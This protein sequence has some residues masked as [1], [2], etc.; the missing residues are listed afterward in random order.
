MNSV[1]SGNIDGSGTLVLKV[2]YTRD[3]YTITPAVDNDKAGTVSDVGSYGYENEVCIV[4]STNPG[5]T[6]LGWYE[7][8]TRVC[9]TLTFIFNAEKTVTYTAKWSAD[10]ATYTVNYYKETFTPTGY[11][12][13]L[14]D[15]VIVTSQTG[16]YVSATANSVDGYVLNPQTSVVSGEV[17][18]DNSLVLEV[19]YRNAYY[20]DGDYIYLGEYPQT[21]KSDDVTITKTIDERGYYLGSDGFYYAKYSTYYFKVEPIRWR[22]LTEQDGKAFLFCDIII[23][24]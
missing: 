9:D 23:E 22:I 19:K 24:W 14:F 13:E 21:L 2:Y 17:V 3:V 15:S 6:F 12:T 16:E 8:T 7:G 10:E 18:W 4:A 5:Y 20:R 1:L 11:I